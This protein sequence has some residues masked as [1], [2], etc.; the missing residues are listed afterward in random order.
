M[1]TETFYEY[2]ANVFYP[3]LLK[4][5][6]H[7]PIVLYLDKHSS[8]VTIPLVSFCREKK[9]ELISLYPNAT[10]I[11]QPLD[12]AL[13]HP[14]KDLWRKTVPKWK[15]E[16]ETFRLK[17]EQFPAVLKKKLKLE[18]TGKAKLPSA[19]TSDDWWKAQLEKEQQRINIKEEKA[20][21]K[22]MVQEEKK[23]EE[24]EKFKVV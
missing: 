4:E 14:F 10:H 19:G 22:K 1:T 8:H 9:I 12:V 13:F 5:N 23:I 6:I 18:A 21:K 20:A 2:I 15:L 17:K 24:K 7:F 11:I 3:W 16:N